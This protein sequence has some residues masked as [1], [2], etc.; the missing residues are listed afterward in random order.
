MKFLILNTAKYFQNL[1]LYLMKQIMADAL[2]K[3][4]TTFPASLK[5]VTLSH[6]V[7]WGINF[8]SKTP[9]PFSY[10]AIP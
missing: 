1:F 5:R 7:H 6:S 3:L 10:Q 2:K 9:P 4:V 8:P